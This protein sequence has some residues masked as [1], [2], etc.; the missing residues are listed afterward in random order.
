MTLSSEQAVR[1]VKAEID[2]LGKL[3][4]A[5]LRGVRTEL[6]ALAGKVETQNGRVGRVED[7]LEILERAKIGTDAVA[8]A[9]KARAAEDD[10]R[11]T[12]KLSRLQVWLA[13]GGI[14][15]GAL[16]GLGGLLT[17]VHHL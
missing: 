8:A 1:A 5:E 4:A 16:A 15:V 9:L 17:I 13:A 11:Q 12:I 10:E 6:H 14:L 2:G 7:S 3:M